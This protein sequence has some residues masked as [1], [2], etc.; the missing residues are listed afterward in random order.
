MQLYCLIFKTLWL[1]TKV[2]PHSCC[3]VHKVGRPCMVRATPRRRKNENY[4]MEI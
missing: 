3:C 4:L 2:L 1:Q